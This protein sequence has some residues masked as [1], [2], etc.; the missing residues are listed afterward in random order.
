M[1][2]GKGDAHDG[3]QEDNAAYHVQKGNLPPA[4]QDPEKVH[5]HGHATGLIGAVHQLVPE[6]PQGIGPQLEQLK[7]KRNADERKAHH[8]THHIVD[9]GDEDAAQ[10]QPENITDKVHLLILLEIVLGPEHILGFLILMGEEIL[11]P[12]TEIDVPSP[13]P[14]HGRFGVPVITCAK[15]TSLARVL[16]LCHNQSNL[17]INFQIYEKNNSRF[18]RI[19]R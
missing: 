1:L 16:F 18:N 9:E 13:E 12:R 4:Q 5:H 6:R 3:E 19:I 7:P 8:Q 11:P 2:Q 17:N 10:Q 15:L 14:S